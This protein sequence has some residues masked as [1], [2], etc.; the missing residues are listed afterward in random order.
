MEFLIL[1]LVMGL[2]GFLLGKWKGREGLGFL[3]GFLLGPIGWVIMLL[4][5]D[6]R[7][8]CPHCAGPLPKE[9]VAR[10]MHCGE[11]L[12]RQK[13]G[14]TNHV[15]IDPIAQWAEQEEAKEKAQ[16]VL[17]VPEHLRG[18]KVDEV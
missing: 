10:C 2:V 5:D 1:W 18:R 9:K 6:I 8:K 11:V 13:G 4:V 14:K 3:L 12:V 7:A 17:A 16:T 15:I